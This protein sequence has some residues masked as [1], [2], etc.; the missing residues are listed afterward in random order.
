MLGDMA[1]PRLVALIDQ[2]KDAH[3]V[4]DAELARRIGTSRENLRLWRTNG[5]WALPVQDNLRSVARAIGQPYRQVLSAVLVD[6]GYLTDA[7]GRTPRPYQ[8]VLHD[9][10]AALTEASRLTNQPV[11]HNSS[12]RWEPDPDPAAALPIDWAEFVTRALAGAAA[13]VGG[14]EKILSGRPGSWEAT[15]VRETLHSTVGDDW[16]ELPQ[17]RTDPVVVDLWVDNILLDIDDDPYADAY[18][19]LGRREDEIPEPD[20]VDYDRPQPPGF[21]WLDERDEHG[22]LTWPDDPAK[23]AAVEKHNAETPPEPLTAGEQAQQD[24]FDHI[25]ALRK[26]LDNL[27]HTELSTYAE[28]LTRAITSQLARLNFNV[29][30]HVTVGVVPNGAD[31]RYGTTPLIGENY[32]FVD[33]TI[34]AAIAETPGPAGPAG[35]AVLR[36]TPLERAE[37]DDAQ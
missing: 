29:P 32:S 24:A 16:K 3:G 26:R 10:V 13:N 25:A 30:V 17:F 7:E 9:A 33:E 18:Y 15:R 11:R 20:D 12:G 5:L 35:P 27:R 31:L 21:E 37:R 36:R 19:E 28:A 8:E 23:V 1:I 34:A 4:S 6:V 22:R 2:Y 14:V